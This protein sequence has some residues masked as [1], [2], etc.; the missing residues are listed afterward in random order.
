MRDRC[1]FVLQMETGGR[2]AALG[3]RMTEFECDLSAEVGFGCV[4]DGELNPVAQDT[5]ADVEGLHCCR[6]QKE[7]DRGQHRI[8]QAGFKDVLCFLTHF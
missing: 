3:H 2:F 6:E 5:R 8:T 1:G 4:Q 7:Q